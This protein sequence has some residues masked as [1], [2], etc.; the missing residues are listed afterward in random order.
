MAL[1]L[2]S[3]I[4]GLTAKAALNGSYT[5]NSTGV[6]S[7]TN[8]LTVS[9]AVSDLMTGTRAD[10]GPVNGPGVSGAVTLRITPGSGPYTEQ[11]SI[12]AIPGATA[13]KFVRLTGGPTRET[14]QFANT[15][16]TDR[17]VIRLT[18]AKHIKLD[19]LTLTNT[20]ITYGYGVWFQASADSNFVTN[21]N[22]NVDQTSTLSN[23]CGITMSGTS[24]TT[25][26]LNGNYNTI[27]GNVISGGYYGISNNGNGTTPATYAQRNHIIDNEV[28]NFYYY[29]IR[30]YGQNGANIV[31]NTVHARS[32]GSSAGYGMYIYYNDNFNIERN[33][34]YDVGTYGIYTYYANYQN[35]LGTTRSRVVNNMVGGG[36]LAAT[37]Y[38]I[39]MSTNCTRVDFFH[40]SVSMNGGAGRCLYIVSGS[41]NDIRNN[42]LSFTGSTAGYALYVAT[43]PNV[44][45]VDFNDYY[46]QAPQTSSSSVWPIHRAP[47]RVVAATT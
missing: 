41:L 5:I 24:P 2:L 26:G 21:S 28:K 9:S 33:R 10:G 43:T 44:A 18:G 30:H 12:G 19:S 31:G 15:T 20:G 42:V 8:Y 1:L 25:N 6:A 3:L 39:Y 7:A 35:G 45:T 11:V 13:T 47:F 34:V 17:H 22:I 36:F 16:T 14:I 37:S 29:G 23:F 27:Q 32:S 38:G 4:G 46:A 40:N